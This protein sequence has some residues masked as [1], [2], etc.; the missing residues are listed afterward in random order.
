MALVYR[1]S[2]GDYEVNSCRF[3]GPL[4]EWADYFLHFIQDTFYIPEYADDPTF[5]AHT[6]S[7]CYF[8]FTGTIRINASN[9]IAYCYINGPSR[10]SCSDVWGNTFAGEMDMF[11][12]YNGHVA[13]NTFLDDVDLSFCHGKTFAGNKVY[14]K[15]DIDA[16]GGRIFKNLFLGRSDRWKRPGYEIYFNNMAPG[17]WMYSYF[18]SARIFNNNISNLSISNNSIT[19]LKNNNYFP[20]WLSFPS[21]LTLALCFMTRSTWI[22]NRTCEA[23]TPPSDKRPSTLRFP[24]GTHKTSTACTVQFP[25]RS[26][27]MNF[28]WSPATCRIPFQ[29]D[30]VTFCPSMN[31]IP[32]A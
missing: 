21:I 32:I 6:V 25:P 20:N 8:D 17:T 4:D 26:E 16:Q 23:P 10:L 31:A 5:F 12:L 9:Q 29:S 15:T 27:R 18:N 1:G 22:R 19:E 7:H 13:G 28:A 30:A 24:V 3:D 2:K 14:G 11:H